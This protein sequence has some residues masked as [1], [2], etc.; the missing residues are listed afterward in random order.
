MKHILIIRL[1]AMGDVAMTVPVLRALIQQNDS[2][3]ITVLTR[4]FFTPL[5]KDFENV[6]VCVPD[7]KNK[8]KGF[9]GVLKLFNEL[10]KLKIDVVADLHNVLRSNIIVKLF[11]LS[12]VKCVQIDKGRKEKKA[13]TKTLLGKIRNPI[14]TT[15]ER[16]ADVFRKLHFTVELS[17]IKFADN[18]LFTLNAESKFANKLLVGFAPFATYESKS[19]PLDKVKEIVDKLSKIKNTNVLLFGGGAKE[20][21]ILDQLSLDYDAV[22][23]MVHKQSFEEE[24][25]IIANLKVMISM[26]SGNGHLAAMFGIPVITIWGLT[27]PCLGFAPFNQA[28]EY[29]ILPDL[30]KFPFI[31]T[32]VY[33][34]KYPKEYLTCFE[35]I[36]TD[37]IIKKVTKIL[38]KNTDL[39]I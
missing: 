16:Y 10:S 33:G 31:P 6:S 35:T 11:Q 25:N 30:E 8:H 21:A 24:L 14:K 15:H 4:Q 23:S 20:K 38:L 2:I 37:D 9:L 26:D 27:H 18:N 17:N 3:K 28:D 39:K 5:F 7:L 1:S 32:S 13:L 12:G 34:N 29:Q 36:N 22:F 19:L